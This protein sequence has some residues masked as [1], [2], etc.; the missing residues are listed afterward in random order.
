M[1]ASLDVI[2]R[3]LMAGSLKTPFPHC[4][5]LTFINMRDRSEYAFRAAW[6]R[7]VGRRSTLIILT[8]SRSDQ[9]ITADARI[10]AHSR[11][12]PARETSLSNSVAAL[13]EN[14]SSVEAER[15]NPLKDS[16]W[17]RE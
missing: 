16:N 6:L 15:R 12:S 2:S 7:Y 3:N 1:S 8:T 17:R 11:A 4:G 14:G 9:L 5:D 10:M 13:G